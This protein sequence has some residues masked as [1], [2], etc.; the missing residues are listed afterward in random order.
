MAETQVHDKRIE[1]KYMLDPELSLKVRQWARDHLGV[2]A[3][4][5]DAL[6]DHY[7]VHTLYLDTPQLDLFHRTGDVGKAKHR[8]RRYGDEATLWVET[9]RK[10]G[11]VVH[12]NRTAAS[13]AEVMD[14]L[15]NPSD[16]TSWCGDWFSAR[17]SQRRLRPTIQVH[18]RR[19]ARTS[20]IAGESLRLTIDSELQSSPA[21]GWQVAST[22]D[23]LNRDRHHAAHVEILELK[24]HNRMPPL[25]KELLRTFAIPATGFS[26]FRTG[27]DA[28]SLAADSTT[29]PS[30]AVPTML[31]E[32]FTNA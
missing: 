27:I 10:Q 21:T 11:N 7:D 25:F 19:F 13:E 23:H 20:T 12:K 4:C 30:P 5:H 18:Y 24:F 31:D 29:C 3:H 28:W 9:K 1:L 16:S 26:K 2:D 14:R 17:I 8:I 6:S 15:T 22:A 32:C